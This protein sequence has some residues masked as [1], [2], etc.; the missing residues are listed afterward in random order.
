[1]HVGYLC[2][3]S[4]IP[5]K[6]KHLCMELT[7]W[8]E[9]LSFMILGSVSQHYTSLIYRDES[10][11]YQLSSVKYTQAHIC[12]C[13][14]T[15]SLVLCAFQT[16]SILYH[17]WT[18]FQIHYFPTYKQTKRQEMFDIFGYVKS[19]VKLDNVCID[20]NVFRLHYKVKSQLK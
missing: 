6:I 17:N 18:S 16:S 4:L 7:I 5:Q 1:M 14:K 13:L 15:K 11:V 12:L 2:T 3:I 10:L 9:F 19:F 20:N 8:I